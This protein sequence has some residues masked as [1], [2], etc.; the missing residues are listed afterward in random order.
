MQIKKED[1]FYTLFHA[2]IF[3][4]FTDYRYEFDSISLIDRGKEVAIIYP[5]MTDKFKKKM[6][7]LKKTE[8]VE[9]NEK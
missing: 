1:G 5:P 4:F 2:A 9:K 8:K 6:E 3:I 7:E